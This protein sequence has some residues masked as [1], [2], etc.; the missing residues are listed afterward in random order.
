MSEWKEQDE[1]VT[2]FGTIKLAQAQAHAAGA[3]SE[4]DSILRMLG[5]LTRDMDNAY[6]LDLARRIIESREATE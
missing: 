4:R 3:K 1:V 5:E 6:G 2:T